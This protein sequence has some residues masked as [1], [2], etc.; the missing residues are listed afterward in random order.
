MVQVRRLE[1][2]W[3]DTYYVKFVTELSSAPDEGLAESRKLIS[4]PP[5]HLRE[6]HIPRRPVLYIDQCC[7]VA[8]L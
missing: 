2:F 8:H 5:K 6:L 3:D 1:P 7:F 4:L